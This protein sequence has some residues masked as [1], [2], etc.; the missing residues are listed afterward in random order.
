[1]NALSYHVDQQLETWIVLLHRNP[2]VASRAYNSRG[3]AFLRRAKADGQLSESGSSKTL[4]SPAQMPD[5]ALILIGYLP[6][7]ANLTVRLMVSSALIA[8]RSA[9]MLRWKSP[10]APS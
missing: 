10:T 8:V 6:C 7:P 9:M 3:K 5:K 1:M 4:G 2:T